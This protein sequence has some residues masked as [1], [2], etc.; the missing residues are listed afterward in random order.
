MPGSPLTFAVFLSVSYCLRL[1]L[2]VGARLF[3]CHLTFVRSIKGHQIGKPLCIPVCVYSMSTVCF[4]VYFIVY[5]AQI[6]G[7]PTSVQG[8]YTLS[9]QLQTTYGPIRFVVNLECS[10]IHDQE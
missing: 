7:F 10:V 4:C 6:I 9:I 5:P 3:G 8:I 1:C 2:W